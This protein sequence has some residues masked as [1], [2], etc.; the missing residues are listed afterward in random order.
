MNTPLR[1]LCSILILAWAFLALPTQSA[2][3]VAVPITVNTLED[4]V[5]NDSYCSLREAIT[6]ATNNTSQSGCTAGSG[7][8]TIN[9]SVSG[10]ITL[11]SPLP[12]ILST[13]GKVTIDGGNT[14]TL[15]DASEN[16]IEMI[17]LSQGNLE[18]KNI[19]LTNGK[20]GIKTLYGTLLLNH[21][22]LAHM[23][24]ANAIALVSQSGAVT[25]QN[26][27]FSD[28]LYG[29]YA[30]LALSGD[31]PPLIT[32]QN[33][34]FSGNTYGILLASAPGLVQTSTFSGN[35]KFSIL[36]AKPLTIE[37]STFTNNSVAN[38]CGPALRVGGATVTVTT[39]VFRDNSS[40]GSPARGGA[41]CAAGAGT[42]LT[43]THSTFDHNSATAPDS[44]PSGGAVYTEDTNLTISDSTFIN[45]IATTPSSWESDGGAIFVRGG[46]YNI[47]LT[48]LT[49]A[50]N[51]AKVGAALY[52]NSSNT[53]LKNTTIYGNILLPGYFPV[54]QLERPYSAGSLTISNT[55]IAD[56][57]GGFNCNNWITGIS[58]SFATDDTCAGAS[59]VTSSELHLGALGAYGGD[60]ATYPLLPG[61]A[62]INAGDNSTC[63][64]SDARGI[65]RP[66]GGTCDA[67]AFESR[68]FNLFR[69]TGDG[70]TAWIAAAFTSP[71]GVSI[72]SSYNEP[73]NGGVITF[74]APSSGAS[75]TFAP[76]AT[77][78]I[79]SAK[80][81]SSTASLAVTANGYPG[82]YTVTASTSGANTT[83]SYTLTNNALRI[84][85]P[86]ISR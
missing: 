59:Q 3:A 86:M 72:T 42:N 58:S 68:G 24:R 10:T 82:T 50:T 83:I 47:D 85:L 66:Q 48:N 39:S 32:V 65:A 79:S 54:A 19:T 16:G 30:S 57:V 22:T 53:S 81:P 17:V 31:T 73:V 51:S 37:G 62:A 5:E 70:Q 64:A 9:F 2:H 36:A 67:G 21:V 38:D 41:V 11:I 23:N 1:V 35:T 25:V 27:T 80:I 18:L 52:I 74:T 77:A 40:S 44:I 55:I 14:I 84:F 29:L 60:V 45:N 46:G 13:G 61:S 7:D 28:N 12:S 8:D 76:S 15:N 69:T 71:L 78:P 34:T 63:A 26:S 4:N 20:N 33:S 56:A 43:I 6:A 75:A 49:I